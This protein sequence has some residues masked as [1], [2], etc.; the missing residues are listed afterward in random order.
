V[1]TV[2]EECH[3]IAILCVELEMR[4]NSALLVLYVPFL[5]ENKLNEYIAGFIRE[6]K[7]SLP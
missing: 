1:L 2:E 3:S 7:F 5:M 4:V 6:L